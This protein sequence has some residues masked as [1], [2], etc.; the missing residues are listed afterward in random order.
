[1][2]HS[3]NYGALLKRQ[4]HLQQL[5]AAHLQPFTIEQV[6]VA[7]LTELGELAQELKPAWAW[8]QKPGGAKEINRER[9]LSEAA[10]VLHFALLLDLTKDARTDR[11]WGDIG[12]WSVAERM[13]ISQLL[14]FIAEC[15]NDLGQ[16]LGTSHTLCA[17]VERY[18]F[19][20]DDLARAYWEKTEENLM[21]W[22]EVA[23][24]R[25]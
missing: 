18:G 10:D 16:G 3:T 23:D 11:E 5:G 7:L 12:T 14:D 6:R 8:W 17:I 2:T 25:R 20:P 9:V 13:P 22:R 21:R 24:E 19:T 1:M 4:A 15:L